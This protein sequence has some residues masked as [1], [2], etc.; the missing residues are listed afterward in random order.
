[1]VSRSG[2]HVTV[3]SWYA[4]SFNARNAAVRTTRDIRRF[5]RS[6]TSDRAHGGRDDFHGIPTVMT[7]I[8]HYGVSYAAADDV[9]HEWAAAATDR[10]SILCPAR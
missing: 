3:K 8:G 2:G 7:S 9:R 6:L 4:I 10:S 1:M 5:P